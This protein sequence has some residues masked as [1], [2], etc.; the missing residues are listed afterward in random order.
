VFKNTSEFK[1]EIL[2]VDIFA[3]GDASTKF[4][5]LDPENLPKVASEGQWQS[6]TW[7]YK[8]ENFPSF[9]RNIE[10]RV[11]PDLQ[12]EVSG[13]IVID[14]IKLILASITGEV[15]YEVAE[16]LLGAEQEENVVKINS[17]TDTEIET[18]LSLVNNGSAPLNEVS[19]QIG[20]FTDVF[21]PPSIEE[22][23]LLW[24]NTEIEIPPGAISIEAHSPEALIITLNSLKDS[25]TGKLNPGSKL[26]AVFPVRAINPAQ[27]AEFKP[28]IIYKANTYPLGQPIEYIPSV[29]EVPELQV[30]HIRRK[31]RKGKEIIPIGSIGNYQ[32][33]IHF[34]NIGNVTLEHVEL[35]DIVL[36]SFTYGEFSLEPEKIAD[37]KE[38]DILLWKLEALEPGEKLEITYNI[39][40]EGEYSPKGAQLA[41]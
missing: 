23:K 21:Q 17:Y 33:V 36:D 7:T 29:E 11:I 2:D 18:T 4:V 31:Y 27:D 26:E 13:S 22:V 19:M 1:V 30:V 12:A 38:V 3:T 20:N 8:S 10:F 34:E 6:N 9:K 5:T 41:F 40:G 15:A 16:L 39:R 35:V 37:E 28:V 24:N 32:I 25:S 14:E